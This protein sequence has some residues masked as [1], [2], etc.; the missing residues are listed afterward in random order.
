MDLNLEDCNL[1]S[2]TMGNIVR[3]VREC[4]QKNEEITIDMR[5]NK[6]IK[7]ELLEQLRASMENKKVAIKV[8]EQSSSFLTS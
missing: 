1:S 6:E 4:S 5:R 7:K 3:A 8:D 2:E